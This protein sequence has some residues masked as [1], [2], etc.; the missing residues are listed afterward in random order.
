MD[1]GGRHEGACS[2][3]A[4]LHCVAGA[5]TPP[6]APLLCAQLEG[7]QPLAKLAQLTGYTGALDAPAD[8][9]AAQ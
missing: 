1:P 4:R 8:A 3:A 7:D 6:D 9:E 5:L 2:A